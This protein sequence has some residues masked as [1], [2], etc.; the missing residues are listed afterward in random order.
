MDKL[1]IIHVLYS[2]LGGNGNVVFPLLET[3][4]GRNPEHVAVFY[5]VEPL[6]PAYREHCRRLGRSD[7]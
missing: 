4:F 1:K 3:D 5:G 7:Q 2:G 6:L